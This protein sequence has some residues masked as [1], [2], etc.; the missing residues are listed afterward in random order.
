MAGPVTR[1]AALAGLLALPACTTTGPFDEA[2]LA[3]V[4]SGERAAVLLR[5]VVTDPDGRAMPAFEHA[6]GD[7]GLGL[8]RG[9]FDTGGRPDHRILAA[10]FPS[11]TA[12]R[13]GALI[14]FLAPGYHYLAFQGARRTDA[15]S[16]AAQ[17]RTLPRWRIAVPPGVRLLYAGTFRMR[18]QAIG[19]LFGGVLIGQLDQAATVVEADTAWAL[20]L[21]ERDLPGLGPP[22]TRLAVRHAGP[23]LLGMPPA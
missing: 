7:D 5:I 4:R 17:F 18:A 10:R 14:L 23:V 13:D 20:R 12:R 15:F 16:Y 2:V 8:A 3:Q 1:R 22:V 6:L 11:E 19:L 9:D 21:A